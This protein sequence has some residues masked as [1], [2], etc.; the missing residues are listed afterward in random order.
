MAVTTLD[1]VCQQIKEKKAPFWKAFDGATLINDNESSNED[2]AIHS[3]RECIA[4]IKQGTIKIVISKKSGKEKNEGGDTRNLNYTYTIDSTLAG[5]GSN[6]R[7]EFEQKYYDLKEQ[8]LKKDHADQLQTLNAKIDLLAAKL[9]EKDEDD[10]DVY[11]DD[12]NEN[13][14]FGLLKPY[15]P[16]LMNKLGILDTTAAAPIGNINT[17]GSTD[18]V[19]L[20]D[21]KLKAS[22]AATRILRVDN[23]AGD[24]LLMLADLAEKKPDTYVMALNYLKSM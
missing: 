21:Q 17:Q 24:H 16:A 15:V 11:D 22:Q 8:I 23:K 4:N 13:S 12:E 5:T 10:N 19:D 18:P 14:I 9:Q 20:S 6:S 2:K 1:Y 3:L 7:S